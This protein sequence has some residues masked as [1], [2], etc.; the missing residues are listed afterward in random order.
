MGKQL[1]AIHYSKTTTC[2]AYLVG[3]T[4]SKPTV[5]SEADG[6][7]GAF[8]MDTGTG[9]LFTDDAECVYCAQCAA[10]VNGDVPHD[11]DMA[12]MIARL[13]L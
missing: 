11:A 1:V 13:G 6:P 7:M 5:I 4:M 3:R 9:M 2:F 8:Y 10:E 12:R